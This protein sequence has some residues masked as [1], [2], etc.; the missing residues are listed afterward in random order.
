VAF[1]ANASRE[2][3][4]AL[5]MAQEFKLDPVISGGREADQVAAEIKARNARV[6]YNINYPTR[7]RA[8]AP[9][10]DESIDVLRGRANAPK[11]PAALDKAG[12]LFAFSASGVREP[13]D[14]V[15]NVARAV[16]EGLP[17][18][19]AIRALTINAAKIA[20]ADSRLGSI[21][22]GKIANLIV[23]S[24]DLFDDNTQVKHVFIDGRMVVVEPPAPQ[25]GGGRGRGM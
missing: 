6:I 13:R 3:L 2:I 25:R 7:S 1:E 11:V 5:D 16:R 12:I 19:A 10:A 15:R 9:D 4:R 14:F 8:L 17:A 20:G 21:E 24:G 23:T 22:K 18:D